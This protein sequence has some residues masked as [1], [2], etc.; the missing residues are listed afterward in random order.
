MNVYFL[1]G[2]ES[3]NAEMVADC[4]SDALRELGHEV[5]RF[6]GGGLVETKLHERDLVLVCT[7]TTG[8]GDLPQNVRTLF[9]DLSKARPSLVHMRYGLIGLGDRNYKDSFLGAPKKWD[10]LLSELGAVR[11]GERLELDA[12]DNPMPDEDAVRWVRAWAP[13]HLR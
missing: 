13:E 8:I 10:A 9:E 6:A 2:T 12:T 5:E 3:G 4:V 1:V 7:S 11:L